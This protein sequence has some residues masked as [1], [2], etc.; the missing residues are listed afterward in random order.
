MI[1]VL[2]INIYVI[3]VTN[4]E[5]NISAA[6]LL[7]RFL[8]SSYWGPSMVQHLL[9]CPHQLNMRFFFLNICLLS[10][11]TDSNI[12]FNNFSRTFDPHHPF[13]HSNS[14]HIFPSFQLICILFFIQIVWTHRDLPRLASTPWCEP[15]TRSTPEINQAIAC[16]GPPQHMQAG[17]FSQIY[18]ILAP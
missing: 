17:P 3:K 2:K 14:S 8:G 5:A 12:E 13:L 11:K 16:F 4:P 10:L 7:H 9:T 1:Y 15:W 18:V 6:P